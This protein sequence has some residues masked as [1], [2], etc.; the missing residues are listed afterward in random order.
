MS[1]EIIKRLGKGSFGTVNLV[2]KDGKIYAMKEIHI[3]DSYPEKRILYEV[4]V[5]QLLRKGCQ[6]Y[7]LCYE[8]H[9]ID[10]KNK[11][12]YI[13][14]DYI[15]NSSTLD[16]YIYHNPQLTSIQYL[17]IMRVLAIGLKSMHDRGIVHRDIKPENIMF[18]AGTQ[19]G[20][21][22]FLAR[23]IDYGTA[24]IEDKKYREAIENKTIDNI[25]E[26]Y[27]ECYQM[28]LGTPKYIAPE[29]VAHNVM[30]FGELYK[31]DIWSLGMTFL[32]IVFKTSPYKLTDDEQ[33]ML[34]KKV[35]NKKAGEYIDVDKKIIMLTLDKIINNLN[36]IKIEIINEKYFKPD[37]SGF[38]HKGYQR[39]FDIIRTC[40]KY[41]PDERVN[42]VTLVKNINSSIAVTLEENSTE[43]KPEGVTDSNI[44]LPYMLPHKEGLDRTIR[45]DKN[46]S[47]MEI[48][49]S[50]KSR[51]ELIY[52][53][54]LYMKNLHEARNPK[55]IRIS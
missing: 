36:P 10:K 47:N 43:I 17:H 27:G 19:S 46:M 26:N 22:N 24:C 49:L 5:L 12:G 29:V 15:K 9:F 11:V 37:K 1:Y 55:R 35:E 51:Q 34:R 38:K 33:E 45:L 52:L 16:S 39:I 53:R 48:D 50:R 30:E 25:V 28:V 32:E 41:D 6:E 7:F 44:Q 42:L 13:I 31:T 18:T 3:S 2:K 54:R 21:G 14:T 23:Y 8:N 20:L 4:A 40:C